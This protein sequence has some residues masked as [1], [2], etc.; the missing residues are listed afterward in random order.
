MNSHFATTRV[1]ETE[2]LPLRIQRN[3][4]AVETVGADTCT[5][6]LDDETR[7]AVAATRQEELY[8]DFALREWRLL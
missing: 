5:A 7:I 1:A 8:T 4:V 3:L 6:D 2:K